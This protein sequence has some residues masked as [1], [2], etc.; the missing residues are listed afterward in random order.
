[1]IL[2]ILELAALVLAAM[3]ML[4]PSFKSHLSTSFIA[5]LA[6][7]LLYPLL[8][9]IPVPVGWWHALP[10]RGLYDQLYT[11]FDFQATG[12]RPLSLI[13]FQSEYSWLALLL[14]VMVFLAVV[15]QTTEKLRSLVLV[16]LGVAVFQALLGLIQYGDGA[17]SFFRFG[18]GADSANGTYPNRDHFAGLLEMAL[19]ISLAML[20]VTVGPLQK[21]THHRRS[22]VLRR[23]AVFFSGRGGNAFIY[24][25]MGL[26]IG[27]GLIFSRSRTGISLG[28][29]GVLLSA[30][31]Y[32]RRL[33]G[34]N[35]FGLIGTV[36]TL[37]GALAIEIGLLPVLTRF[38]DADPTEDLRWKIFDAV[39]SGIQSFFPLGSG[40]GTFPDVFM[41]FQTENLPV[42]INHA[43][44]DYLEWLMEGGLIVAVLLTLFATFYVRQWFVVW[45]K[46][47]WSTFRFAQAGAGIGLLLISLHGLVDFNLHIPANAIYF[48]FLAGLFFHRQNDEHRPS[49]QTNPSSSEPVIV[50][51]PK[52]REIPPENRVNPFAD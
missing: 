1:M 36:V 35:A 13:G 47:H 28:M 44:N 9:L 40:P 25:A 31:L 34:T 23:I 42:F 3:I 43:H 46:G 18:M 30:F 21:A 2:M 27:L 22:G 48:A 24:A 17:D 32:A 38:T 12:F 41:R 33:G 14:P 19:P 39:W 16:F 50:P 11:G 4:R 6:L 49:S 7:L 20:A 37:G 51:P 52:P 29:L 45:T 5:T 8:Y 15:G 26:V 10:G